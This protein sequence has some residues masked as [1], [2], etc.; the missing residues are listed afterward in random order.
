MH[1]S[2]L[3]DASGHGPAP[4][5]RATALRAAEKLLRT[6]KLD[7]AV[8]EYERLVRQDSRDWTTA[9]HLGSLYA[10]AGIIDKSI[11]QLTTVA[12]AMYDEELLLGLRLSDGITKYFRAS[13]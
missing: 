10:R 13:R 7:L 1:V 8:A 2:P 4:T 12:N 11:E 9:I 3:R 5:D 6:G